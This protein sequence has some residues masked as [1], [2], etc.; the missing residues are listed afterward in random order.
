LGFDGGKDVREDREFLDDL[1]GRA[2]GLDAAVRTPWR[3]AALD[4]KRGD[5]APERI[6]VELVDAE[7][8]T[9]QPVDADRRQR[10]RWLLAAP[11]APSPTMPRAADRAAGRAWRRL[12]LL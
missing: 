8:A 7:F 9:R 11:V 6:G 2:L 12:S 10:R 1:V 3:A 5:Q 4:E